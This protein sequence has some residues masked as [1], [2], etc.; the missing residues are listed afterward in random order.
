MNE[1]KLYEKL[2]ALIIICK[3]THNYKKLADT[4]YFLINNQANEIGIRLGFPGRYSIS[5]NKSSKYITKKSSHQK[6]LIHEYL[7]H[8]N[9]IFFNNFNIE[10]FNP[11]FL[12]DL[13]K[14]ELLYIKSKGNLNLHQ[15]PTLFE[16]YFEIKNLEIPNLR[17]KISK[18]KI[19]N[20][21][22]FHMY[23]SLF[24]STNSNKKNKNE[25]N[26]KS[27]IK[28]LIIFQLQKKEE[29][30]KD[31]F[32]E[33]YNPKLLKDIM[34]LKQIK[35]SFKNSHTD[36]IKLTTSLAESISFQNSLS[37]LYGLFILGLFII[38]F[39][40]GVSII[41]LIMINPLLLGGLGFFLLLIL[42]SAILFFYIYWT[43]FMNRKKR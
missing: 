34:I 3:Q 27:G 37:S 33:N 32:Q 8:I 10:I 38:F 16:L 14:A 12:R 31:E 28:N 2:Q 11:E 1:G 7:E 6:E 23:S 19:D 24:S 21:A 42:G 15:I 9:K 22:P 4:G 13:K 5:S 39:C 18:T 43:N 17:K 40:F 26:E 29:A 41:G 36:K 25:T 30:L 35:R 20:I